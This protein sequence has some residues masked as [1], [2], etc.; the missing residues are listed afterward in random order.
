M[1]IAGNTYRKKG[2]SD[3]MVNKRGEKGNCPAKDETRKL[4][5]QQVSK[6]WYAVPFQAFI[7]AEKQ[8]GDNLKYGL[9]LDVSS[10][11]LSVT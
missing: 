6:K 5:G 1:G 9:T 11:G 2:F 4:K 3:M 7:Q 10:H 8:Q